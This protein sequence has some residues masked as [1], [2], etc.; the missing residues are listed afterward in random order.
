MHRSR[1][2]AALFDVPDETFAAETVFWSNAIGRA[3]E[4]E[5]DGG[6]YTCLG[7]LFSGL[8]FCVVRVQSPAEFAAHA[9][10]WDG[11]TS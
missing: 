6:D 1:L 2:T 3:A 9:T 10:T 4:P 5:E 11:A 7:S 8:P